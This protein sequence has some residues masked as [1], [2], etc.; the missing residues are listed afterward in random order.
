MTE[1]APTPAWCEEVAPEGSWRSLFKYGDPA[2][3]KHPNRGL[4]T[5]VKETFGLS[6]EDLAQP[7]TLLEPM[8]VQIPSRLA[9]QHRKAFTVIVGAENIRL[10][11]YHRVRA[12]YG[13]GMIDALRLRHKVIENLP[14]AVL[15][16]RTREEIIAIVQYCDK[17]RIPLYVY[18]GG[19]TVTRGME[20]V[21]N[22]ICLDLS[23]QFNKVI[24][25][26]EIDQ[27]ITV[28]PGIWGP[29]LD[30]V[31][32]HAPEKLG[33]HDRYTCGHFPQ[34]FEHS[35]VGGWVVTRGAGQN[36]TYY[37]KIEDMVI[38]QEYITPRG[39]LQTAP[40]PRS[41]TGPDF[42]QVMMGSEGTFGVLTAVTLRVCKYRPQNTRR[43]S[44]LFRTWDDAL[45]AAREILQGEFGMPSVFRL[46]DPEET[47]MAMHMYHIHGSPADTLLRALGYQ[48]MQRCLLLGSCD[49]DAA[50]ARLVNSKIAAVARKHGAFTLSPFS[51]TQRWEK[52]RFTDPYM[53]E[54]LMDFGILID[55]L[56]C[57]VTWEQ[58]PKVHE[59]V[60]AFVKARPQTICMTHL[61]HAYP[62]GGN[63]YFIFVAR[64]TEIDEYLRLQ[65]GILEAVKNA[66]A[67]ISHHHGVGK[68]TGPWLEEQIGLPCMDVIR[69]LKRH[70]DPHNI[71]NPGGTLGLDMNAEQAAKRWG[72]RE[73]IG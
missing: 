15:A 47:D 59:Q 1:P 58:M 20:A 27:T 30:N 10:D 37:G 65:Y 35:S 72:M 36:S 4:T 66:G 68:Q 56:E 18:G 55:T 64:I 8:D 67:A 61:S 41:A 14:E 24:A 29:T 19:S 51:V 57:A 3:F 44:Y 12:S 43:Y 25:F 9:P 50:Y 39:L 49:G 21:K 26:N 70:F 7:S 45:A 40:Q 16:P 71:C 63:L 52:S 69:A 53:R 42:D 73:K 22:G 60:R 62:Q 34:S 17:H 23:T 5:L 28:Q 11:T 54:D 13:A 32:N 6:D 38:A 2:G 31:L 33:A 48:P 46:S